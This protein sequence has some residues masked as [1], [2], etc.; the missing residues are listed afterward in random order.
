MVFAE[1][2]P[3]RK[4][5]FRADRGVDAASLSDCHL[6]YQNI[7]HPLLLIDGEAG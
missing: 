1:I 4:R 5:F 2:A 6:P 3:S 7:S